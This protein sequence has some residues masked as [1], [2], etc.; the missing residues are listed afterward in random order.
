ME[1]AG[2]RQPN[3]TLAKSRRISRKRTHRQRDSGLR[4]L[5]QIFGHFFRKMIECFG[6]FARLI[7]GSH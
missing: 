6:I 2:Y 7:G 4:N 3:Q 1:L 5:G